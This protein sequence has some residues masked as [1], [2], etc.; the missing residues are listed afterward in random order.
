MRVLFEDNHILAL[1]KPPGVLTQSDRTGDQSLLEMGK[2]YLKEKY[3]KPGAVFLGMVHRLDRPTGGVLLFCRTSKAA[4]RVSE[5]FRARSVEKR[6]LALCQG[7]PHKQ[8]GNLAHSLWHDEEKRV[9][10]VVPAGHPGAREARLSYQVLAHREG[11]ALLSVQLET[12]RKHQIRCQLSA[13]GYPL[14]GDRKY[15][16]GG[17]G[18]A[19]VEAIGL[20][21]CRLVIQH[22]VSKQPLT[23]H[24]YPRHKLWHNFQSEIENLSKGAG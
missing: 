21:A 12:G 4:A 16:G 19:V 14:S 18:G 3:S 22:P 13:A 17:Q 9:S 11:Q 24:S 1:E 10:R 23:L 2:A 8:N 20:W 6:Y 7:V 15:G 5:Q